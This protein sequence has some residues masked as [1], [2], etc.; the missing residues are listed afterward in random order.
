MKQINTAQDNKPNRLA[1]N[2][3]VAAQLLSVSTP[4]I[5]N[6]IKQGIL[7]GIRIGGRVLVPMEAL[8]RLTSAE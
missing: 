6:Y 3:A 5:R 1:V 7:P 4:T 2:V 8:V